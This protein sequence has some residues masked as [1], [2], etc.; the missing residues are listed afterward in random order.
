MSRIIPLALLAA[1]GLACGSPGDGAEP[2]TDPGG[3]PGRRG[4]LRA[5]LRVPG[6]GEP[7]VILESGLGAAGTEEFFGSL[8]QIAALTRVCTYD[9]A[10]PAT[11]S[12]HF[13]HEDA[14]DVVL[15]AI[16]QVVEA[17]RS[18][19]GLAPCDETFGSMVA[20]CVA[21]GTAPEPE[22]APA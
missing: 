13:V 9:R 2:V 8:D 3:W 21:R 10:A 20:T 6:E 15:A 14:P 19:S 11:D 12:G 5:R 18:G 22:L 17:A 1:F 4:R 7:T 16:E